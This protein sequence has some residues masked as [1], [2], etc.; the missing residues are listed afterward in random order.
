MGT[1]S[2]HSCKVNCSVSVMDVHEEEDDSALKVQVSDPERC[3]T[4]NVTYL[5][6]S[7]N[8]LV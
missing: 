5:Q 4:R 6:I 8:I 7:L 1:S 3:C 2:T